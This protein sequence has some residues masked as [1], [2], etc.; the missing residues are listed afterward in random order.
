MATLPPSF[1]SIVHDPHLKRQSQY[2]IYEWM[3]LLYWYI[4]PIRLEL[5]WD[6]LLLLNFSKLVSI[7]EFSITIK[8]RSLPE[9][10]NLHQDIKKFLIDFESIYAQ[11]DP[12]KVFRYNYL[13]YLYC[14][15]LLT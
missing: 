3:A 5:N 1:C 9:I 13:F 15:Y 4:L 10:N 14:L 6:P 7:I 12:K 8:P 2:K 11:N